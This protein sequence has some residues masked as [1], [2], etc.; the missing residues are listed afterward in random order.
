MTDIENKNSTRFDIE[1]DPRNPK[2]HLDSGYEGPPSLDFTIPS[3]EIEDVDISLFNLFN[4]R[5]GFKSETI[6][7][8]LSPI[9]ISKPYVSLATGERFALVKKLNPPRDKKSKQLLLP[10]ISIRRTNITQDSTDMNSRG[11]NQMTGRVI[12][13]QRLSSKDRDYQ[14]LFNKLAIENLNPGNV[15]STRQQ[16]EFGPNKNVGTRQGTIMEPF[17]GNNVWEI[18]SIPSPQF[19]T[20]SYEVTFWT[21]YSIHMNSMIMQLLAAQLPQGK[22]FRLNTEKGY[23]FIATLGDEVTSADNFEDFGEQ[24]R[25]IRYTFSVT[26]KAFLLAPNGP[27]APVSVRKTISATEI[28]F[29]MEVTPGQIQSKKP[30]R[31]EGTINPYEL[32]DIEQ[33][34]ETA[35][36][37]TTDQR[38]LVNK[39]IIDQRTG[40]KKNVYAKILESNQKSGETIYFAQNFESLDEF[41]ENIKS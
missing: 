23:W 2:D 12:I 11:T 39:T 36:T 38:F 3:C 7:G 33:D 17:L 40:K 24:K 10:A 25:V 30:K 35:E 31:P 15:T 16:G 27:G 4:E 32:T 6:G 21:Q 29:G 13:K 19:Y 28:S 37:T 14:S 18:I 5:I 41:L 20:A 22:M 26:V 8:E 34:P 9:N 1:Q